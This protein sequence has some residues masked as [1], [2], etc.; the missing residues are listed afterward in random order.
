[1]PNAFQQTVSRQLES[2][3]LPN[4]MKVKAAK[5][6]TGKPQRLPQHLRLNAHGKTM[7][8]QRIGLDI[9]SFQK[10]WYFLAQQARIKEEC[11]EHCEAVLLAAI[12]PGGRREPPEVNNNVEA[13]INRLWSGKG[14]QKPY[15]IQHEI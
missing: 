9:P 13:L 1:M 5:W 7:T 12:P 8:E 3:A 4:N 11:H 14:K 2:A 15:P 6:N 10:G